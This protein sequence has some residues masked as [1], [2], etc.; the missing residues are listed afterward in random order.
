MRLRARLPA[1]I[2]PSP[3]E[4]APT[5]VDELIRLIRSYRRQGYAVKIGEAHPKVAN[6]A[7]PVVDDSGQCVAAITIVAY[8]LSLTKQRLGGLI[9][10]VSTTAREMSERIHASSRT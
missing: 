6:I 9:A 2:S 7:A 5:D 1:L 10:A 8:E 4:T 3:T